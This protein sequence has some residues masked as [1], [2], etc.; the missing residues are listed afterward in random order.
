MGE[1]V[2]GLLPGRKQFLT[3]LRGEANVRAG[4]GRS[5]PPSRGE[6]RAQVMADRRQQGC[7]SPVRLG[8]SRGFVRF[9]IRS[10]GSSCR[11]SS[12]DVSTICNLGL[13]ALTNT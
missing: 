4:A 3:V 6:R 13:V 8:R 11:S 7:P 9:R 12:P 1:Q 10:V 2:E 5:P